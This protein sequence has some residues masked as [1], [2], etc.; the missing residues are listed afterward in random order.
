LGH[1]S[2]AVVLTIIFSTESFSAARTRVRSTILVY[3][4]MTNKVPS[5][6]CLVCADTAMIRSFF[7]GIHLHQH[8]SRTKPSIKLKAHLGRLTRPFLRVHYMNTGLFQSKRI[9]PRFYRADSCGSIRWTA[10]GTR[11]GGG[12]SMGAWARNF[13][14]YNAILHEFRYSHEI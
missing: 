9:L 3:H 1:V 14:V 10:A 2:G 8:F 6:V 7:R 13:G 5:T 12:Q 11:R 4:L